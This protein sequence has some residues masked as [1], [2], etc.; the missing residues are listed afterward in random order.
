MERKQ[1]T[2]FSAIEAG[3]SKEDW[4]LAVQERAAILEYDQRIARPRADQLAM[5]LTY[6]RY[7]PCPKE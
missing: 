2:M 1:P 5:A 4:E 6:D 3:W 7:G